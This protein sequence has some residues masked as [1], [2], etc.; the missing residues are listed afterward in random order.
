M[1]KISAHFSR[2]E[3]ACKC[4]CGYDTADAEL[5]QVLEWLR[6][7]CNELRGNPVDAPVTIVINS[8]CRC[9][10][11]NEAEGGAKGSQHLRARAAD[12]VVKGFTPHEVYDILNKQYPTQYGLGR[13]DTFTHIDTRQGP[14]RW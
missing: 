8:A 4:G 11:H 7:H 13:Y 1:A 14:A 3:F 2:H 10:A 9:P 12:I 5:V 6:A